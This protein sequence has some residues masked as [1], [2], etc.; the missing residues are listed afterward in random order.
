MALRKKNIEAIDERQRAALAQLQEV[1]EKHRAMR[2]KTIDL[3]QEREAMQ[4]E[5]KTL[6]EQEQKRYRDELKADRQ[7]NANESAGERASGEP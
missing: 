6:Y 2:E 3:Q 7:L 5:I 1:K 4:E